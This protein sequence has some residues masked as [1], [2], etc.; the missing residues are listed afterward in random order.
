MRQRVCYNGKTNQ[1]E[2]YHEG[3]LQI[4]VSAFPWDYPDFDRAGAYDVG[5]RLKWEL[6]E[7][8]IVLV[9]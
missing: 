4:D 7:S 2:R 9:K 3:F 5:Y 1:K 6:K 8:T